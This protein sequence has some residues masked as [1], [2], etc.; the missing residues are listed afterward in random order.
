MRKYR[1]VKIVSA[2]SISEAVVNEK[3]AEI[4]LIDLIDD[5]KDNAG[6]GFSK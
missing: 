2:D 1:L 3:M 6:V 4:I 5:P